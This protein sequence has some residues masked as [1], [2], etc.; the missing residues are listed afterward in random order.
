VVGGDLRS[1]WM[2]CPVARA[3]GVYGVRKLHRRPGSREISVAG[4]HCLWGTFGMPMG[5][6]D[7]VGPV[8]VYNLADRGGRGGEGLGCWMKRSL[9]SLCSTLTTLRRIILIITSHNSKHYVA[10]FRSLL[11]TLRRTKGVRGL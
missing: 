2:G 8:F 11:K 6:V 9:R 3:A 5:T 7:C 10:Q 4:I 1:W